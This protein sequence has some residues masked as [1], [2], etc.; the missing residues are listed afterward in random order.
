MPFK[1]RSSRGQLQ[2]GGLSSQLDDG[3]KPQLFELLSTS[4][5]TLN[6]R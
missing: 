3:K 2:R 6:N 1:Q 4:L 5:K